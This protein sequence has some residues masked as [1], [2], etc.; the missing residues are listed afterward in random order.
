[1][2][3]PAYTVYTYCCLKRGSQ[4]RVYHKPSGF[5]EINDT[6][7]QPKSPGFVIKLTVTGPAINVMQYTRGVHVLRSPNLLFI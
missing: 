3:L 1:M 4:E 6:G 2:G 5:R 7:G